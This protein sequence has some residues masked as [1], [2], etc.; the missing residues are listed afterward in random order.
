MKTIYKAVRSYDDGVYCDRLN[1]AFAD[2]WQYVRASE[3][4]AESVHYSQLRYGYIEYILSK[5]VEEEQ[6]EQEPK[7]Q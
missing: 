3:Y 4:I 5:D 6:A 7:I 1:E 2:G